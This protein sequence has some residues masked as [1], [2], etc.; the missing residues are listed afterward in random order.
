MD[1][2]SNKKKTTK[3][4][5]EINQKR[6]LPATVSVCFWLHNIRSMH[7]VGSVFRTSDALGADTLYLSGYT[8]LPPRAE[9]SKTALGAEEHVPWVSVDDLSNQCAELKK[10][11]YQIISLEQTHSSLLLDNFKPDSQKMC[12]ILGNE[13]TGVDDEL[14]ELSDAVVEIPQFGVK[15]SLNVSVA[16]GIALYDLLQKINV[17]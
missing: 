7:N 6:E 14:L 16:A 17:Q 11:G 1:Q 12:I 10:N 8:P 13:V 4:I 9:I 5:L 2:S 15:H 3:E